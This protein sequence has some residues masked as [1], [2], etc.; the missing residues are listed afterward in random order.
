MLLPSIGLTWA[1]FCSN[2]AMLTSGTMITV[3]EICAG[4]SSSISRSSAMMEAYSVPCA[5][6]TSAST[7][8]GLRAVDDDHRDAGAGVAP[9]R[10]FNGARD[11][12]PARRRYGP[13]GHGWMTVASRGPLPERRRGRQD[14]QSQATDKR[15]GFH[16]SSLMAGL[17]AGAEDCSFCRAPVATG[18]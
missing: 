17:S 4:S 7:G 8:P 12:L 5:P 15:Q 10:H 3:P 6:A 16:R 14:R 11:L 9:G 18:R 1:I 2:D 13:D